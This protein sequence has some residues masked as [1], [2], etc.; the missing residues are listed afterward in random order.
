[1]CYEKKKK[2][3]T[4]ELCYDIQSCLPARLHVEM[5]LL[6]AH[7]VSKVHPFG[8][9]LF[10]VGPHGLVRAPALQNTKQEKSRESMKGQRERPV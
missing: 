3:Q 6:N 8:K 4:R 10:E 1:M 9:V 7:V 5:G 2:K